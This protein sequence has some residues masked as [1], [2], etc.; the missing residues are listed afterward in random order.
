[1]GLTKQEKRS[2]L[3]VQ[4]LDR[5]EVCKMKKW[6]VGVIHYKRILR[7]SAF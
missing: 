4:N 5:E 6:I 2:I 7:T 3:A 1:M